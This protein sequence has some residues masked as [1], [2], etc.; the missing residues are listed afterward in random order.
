MTDGLPQISGARLVR[1][2]ERAGWYIAR[3]DGSHAQ[4]KRPGRAGVVTVSVHKSKPVPSG[5]LRRILDETGISVARLK[6]LL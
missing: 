6:E 3:Q 2:L 1:A 5:T 4:I